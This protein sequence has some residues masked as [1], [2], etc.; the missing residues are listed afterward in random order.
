MHNGGGTGTHEK[1]ANVQRIDSIAARLATRKDSTRD[2]NEKRSPQAAA[3]AVE[4]N[5]NQTIVSW[6]RQKAETEKSIQSLVN[7][8]WC[9]AHHESS[10]RPRNDSRVRC[11]GI[12]CIGVVPNIALVKQMTQVTEK[13]QQ[14]VAANNAHMKQYR[15]KMEEV[16]N[17]N[18]TLVIRV[19]EFTRRM[20]TLEQEKLDV[21]NQNEIQQQ[22]LN[23]ITQRPG[24]VVH[25]QT[26]SEPECCIKTSTCRYVV[27][28]HVATEAKGN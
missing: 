12:S 11:I 5:R 6:M 2:A 16:E 23:D 28:L 22:K 25:P 19:N 15:M 7:H 18:T 27:I 21:L 1:Y 20:Q 13:L 3:F 26:V 9:R 17:V 10:F 14:N 8:A 24:G 4:T